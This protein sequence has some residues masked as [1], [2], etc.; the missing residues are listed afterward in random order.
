MREGWTAFLKEHA[1]TQVMEDLREGT[2]T[3]EQA[4]KRLKLLEEIYE[5]A[6]REESALGSDPGY[7]MLPAL[8]GACRC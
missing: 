2:R 4:A 3:P 1:F 6:E 8:Q 7:G 5:I